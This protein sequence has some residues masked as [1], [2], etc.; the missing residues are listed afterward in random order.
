MT[1]EQDTDALSCLLGPN[2]V[3]VADPI[4]TEEEQ[5]A[6]AD[7]LTAQ[8]RAG[9][10]V[11]NPQDPGAYSTPF[12]SASGELTRFTKGGPR[13]GCGEQKLVWIPSV[14][15]MVDPLPAEL[16]RVRARVIDRLGLHELEEDPYKGSFMSYIE[17][18]TGVHQHRD[19]RLK[20]GPDERLILRCNVLFR[21]PEG[22][23]MP[24][25]DGRI[26]IEIPDRAMWAFYPTELVHSATRVSGGGF[27]GLMSF[28]FLVRP[29]DMWRR[30]FRIAQSFASEYALD[31]G[32]EARRSLMDRLSA[33]ARAAG[34]SDQRLHLL[35]FV[36]SSRGDFSL[37][38]AAQVLQRPPPEIWGILGDLQR[39]HLVESNAS[40]RRERGKV[41]VV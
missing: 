34:I 12:R 32:E 10:L 15:D 4:V 1:L 29:S 41:V 33:P 38:E 7:W 5:S 3:L 25:F 27:R 26:E 23:G 17:P 9:K 19:D 22:G 40:A 36:I 37:Q 24:V 18:G 39:S 13:Q 31:S 14:D 8:R 20:I 30:R 6:L 16:W 21:K 28:G 2:E 35:E 11:T